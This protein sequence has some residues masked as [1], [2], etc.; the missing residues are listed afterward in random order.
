MIEIRETTKGRTFEITKHN[1]EVYKGIGNVV[2]QW[3]LT[4][5]ELRE[6]V[7]KG[8]AILY[9]GTKRVCEGCGGVVRFVTGSQLELAAEK[10][11]LAEEAGH[12]SLR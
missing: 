3:S 8:W 5:A 10:A 2:G 9:Q 7:E 11:K 6:L 12:D 1:F 4:E